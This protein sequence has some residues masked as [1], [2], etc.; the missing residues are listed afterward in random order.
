MRFAAAT[1]LG[2]AELSGSSGAT[3]NVMRGAVYVRRAAANPRG[4]A[5]SGASSQ[6]LPHEVTDC[7]IGRHL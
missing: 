6:K 4:A 1:R 5:S 7:Q 2:P 3:S